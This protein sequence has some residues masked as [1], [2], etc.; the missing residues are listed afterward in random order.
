MSHKRHLGEP[1]LAPFRC[2][3]HVARYR[4]WLRVQLAVPQSE[5][6]DRQLP[7]STSR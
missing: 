1:W 7:S 6:S 4:G 5:M 3:T 2:V